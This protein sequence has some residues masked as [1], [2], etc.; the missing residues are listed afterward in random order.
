MKK[1]ALLIVALLCSVAAMADTFSYNFRS[2]RLADALTR[3][4]EDHPSLRI[5]FIYNELDKYRTSAHIN[6]DDPYDALRHTVGLNPVTIAERDGRFYV[7]ALQHGRYVYTGRVISTDQEPVAGATVMLLAPKDSTVL[8]YG[9]ADA[10]GRFSIPC[11]MRGVIAKLSCVGYRTTFRRLDSFSAGMIIMTPAVVGLDQVNVEADN[12]ALY[13]DRSVFIPTSNQK[14]A[15]QTGTDLIER[16]AIPQLRIGSS[17]LTNT[18]QPV[19][20]FIDY[21]PATD[22][23]LQGMRTAD[24]RRVEYYDFPSDPRFLGKQHVINF[25]MHKYEYGGYVKATASETS[26]TSH[27]AS[28]FAKL[29]HK[30][31]TYDLAGG[32]TINRTSLNYEDQTETFRIPQADGTVRQFER[33]TTT[34]DSRTRDDSYWTSFKALYSSKTVS[35]SNMFQVVFN[36]NPGSWTEGGV[37]YTPDVYPSSSFRS[38]GSK[39]VNSLGYRGYWYFTLP[40]GN[41]LTFTPTYGYSHTNQSTLYSEVGFNPIANGARDDSH[42]LSGSLNFRHSFGKKGGSLT[43]NLDAHYNQ[44]NTHYSGTSTLSDRTSEINIAPG[45]MYAVQISKLNLTASLGFAWDRLSYDG[46]KGQ[47]KIEPWGKLSLQYAFSKR[48]SANASVDIMQWQPS[49]SYLST[50]IVQADPFMWYTGNPTL[51]PMQHCSFD[52]GYTFIP[53]NTFSFS[54]FAYQSLLVNRYVYDYEAYGQGVLRTIKQPMGGYGL[55][56]YG[57]SGTGRFFNR[58]LQVSLSFSVREAHNGAPYNWTKFKPQGSVRVYYYLKKFYFGATYSTPSGESDG[59]MVGDWVDYHASYSLQAGWSNSK[60][61]V[62]VL[63]QNFA[64]AKTWYGRL[65]MSTPV[66]SRTR[67]QYNIGSRPI[68]RISAT[69]TIGYGKR[70]RQGNEASMGSGVSS[71]ILR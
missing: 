41:S 33:A 58:S 18:G 31:M 62:S 7:E 66:Y 3:I 64:Q 10:Q 52:L 24:V 56:I 71:G 22:K 63:A 37:Q 29:Q 27:R 15:A 46:K 30:K 13:A 19:A 53:N 9:I 60:W 28:V 12:A 23:D 20:I 32:T 61:N 57:V 17:S 55:G 44:H 48:H 11:D 35:L 49:S 47:S 4:A 59:I 67:W 65:E 50:G 43:A 5:N 45:L 6:T 21:M 25:I 36:R 40:H 14:N 54:A 51:T 69:Y 68:F 16:M 42:D 2:T 70:V 39:R 38:E 8:T 34:T 26:G 1:T